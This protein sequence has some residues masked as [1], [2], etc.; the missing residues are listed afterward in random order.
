MIAETQV[1]ADFL[2]AGIGVAQPPLGGID[3]LHIDILLDGDTNLFPELPGKIAPG[4]I[5][6]L[7]QFLYPQ[8][9]R[10]P[11]VDVIDGIRYAAGVDM[12][13]IPVKLMLAVHF[14]DN[15]IDGADDLKG[16]GIAGPLADVPKI[17]KLFRRIIDHSK[18]VEI[19][20][21]V[22]LVGLGKIKMEEQQRQGTVTVIAAGQSCRQQVG[23]AGFQRQHLF[24]GAKH[25]GP[26]LYQVQTVEGR[27]Q[28]VRVPFWAD[29]SIT[30]ITQAHI[31][32][33][34]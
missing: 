1:T 34:Y 11:L 2:Y 17:R 26:A 28:L 16:V 9:G 24:L 29:S 12:D 4:D 6:L 13:L 32:A 31:N 15:V 18:P 3:E 30:Y 25:T 19:A 10:Q 14:P 33:V 7:G 21:K 23:L 22:E 20:H 8:L 5:A 27:G